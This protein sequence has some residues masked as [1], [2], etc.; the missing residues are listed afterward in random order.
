MHKCIKV[1]GA[2]VLAGITSQKCATGIT[3]APLNIVQ[4]VEQWH[5]VSGVA[6]YHGTGVSGCLRYQPPPPGVHFLKPWGG[7]GGAPST[8]KPLISDTGDLSR[9]DV[10]KHQVGCDWR[11]PVPRCRARAWERAG[12]Y[13]QM[14]CVAPARRHMPRLDTSHRPATTWQNALSP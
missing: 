14:G 6:R 2:R 8:Q 12:V 3:C 13:S 1:G 4:W 5:R 7:H 10:G 9:A 11:A